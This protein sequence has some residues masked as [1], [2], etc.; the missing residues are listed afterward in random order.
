MQDAP[1]PDQEEDS[2]S[3]SSAP[4]E[5]PLDAPAQERLEFLTCDPFERDAPGDR[6]RSERPDSTE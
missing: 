5:K 2:R 6:E 3:R 1:R 4:S